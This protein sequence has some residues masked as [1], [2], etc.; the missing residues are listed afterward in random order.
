MFRSLHKGSFTGWS[1]SHL[2]NLIYLPSQ[3]ESLF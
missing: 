3:M 1:L 2:D